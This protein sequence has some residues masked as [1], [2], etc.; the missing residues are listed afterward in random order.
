MP[1]EL[2]SATL[3]RTETPMRIL[4]IEDD[5]D[6]ANWL[7]KGLKESGHVV[8]LA[9]DG[10]LGYAMAQEGLHDV[11]IVDRMLP[12]LDGLKVISQLRAEGSK[13]PVLILSA[14]K[15]VTSSHYISFYLSTRYGDRSTRHDMTIF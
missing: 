13:V 4:V 11:L 7:V 2:T 1:A 12:K 10:E 6:A 5:N 14:L 3:G 8:D 15:Q 9:G